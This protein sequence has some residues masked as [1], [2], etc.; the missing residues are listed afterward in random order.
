[1]K[2]GLRERHDK[3]YQWV[4]TLESRCEKKVRVMWCEVR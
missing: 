4:H 2:M 3:T 1:M